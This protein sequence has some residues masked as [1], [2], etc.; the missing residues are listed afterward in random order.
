MSRPVSLVE[1]RKLIISC[2]AVCAERA[3]LLEERFLRL[4]QRHFFPFKCVLPPNLSVVTAFA[5][6]YAALVNV[7]N[8]GK[9]PF[10]FVG[11]KT[12]GWDEI[13]E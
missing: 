10:P 1:G 11:R 9:R 2:H 7:H 12:R 13:S 6:D 8:P 3:M 5:D 4:T